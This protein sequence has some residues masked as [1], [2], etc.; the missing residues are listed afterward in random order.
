MVYLDLALLQY[1]K[2]LKEA[3]KVVYEFT[4]YESVKL[5]VCTYF[6]R[7]LN[8]KVLQVLIIVTTSATMQPALTSCRKFFKSNLKYSKK[9][10]ISPKFFSF[11]KVSNEKNDSYG[12]YGTLTVVFLPGFPKDQ[13]ILRMKI[14]TKFKYLLLILNHRLVLFIFFRLKQAL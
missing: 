2:C 7:N 5:F 14:V 3:L 4:R 12:Y 13:F 6:V 8:N 9:V 11:L 1:S 10:Y